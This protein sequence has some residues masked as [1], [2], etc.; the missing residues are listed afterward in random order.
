MV[1]DTLDVGTYDIKVVAK[2]LPYV[3]ESNWVRCVKPEPPMITIPNI[4]TPNMDGMNDRFVIRNLLLYDHRPLIIKNRWGR[5][6][7]QTNQYNNDW[8]GSNIP[9]GV[10]YGIVAINLNGQVV[11]YPFMVTILHN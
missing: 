6:I 2:N 7:Y 1:S 3:S 4:I 10:Y 9:D 8:D 5:T 11:E